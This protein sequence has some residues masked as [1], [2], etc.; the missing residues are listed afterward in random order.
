MKTCQ[1]KEAN[2]DRPHGVQFHGYEMLTMVNPVG[3][4]LRGWEGEWEVTTHEYRL[5]FFPGDENVLEPDSGDGGTTLRI[6]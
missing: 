6:H 5:F 1:I 2:H 3:Q 4:W